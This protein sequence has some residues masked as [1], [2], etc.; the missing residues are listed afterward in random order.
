MRERKLP[1]TMGAGKALG[2]CFL[3]FVSFLRSEFNVLDFL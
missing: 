3:E 1:R 2:T